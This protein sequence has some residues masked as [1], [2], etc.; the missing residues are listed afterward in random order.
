MSVQAAPE[1]VPVDSSDSVEV[2]TEA[3]TE[4]APVADTSADSGAEA[5]SS[6]EP[7]ALFA[8]GGELASLEKADWFKG[9]GSAEQKTLLAGLQEKHRN[10][11]RGYGGK[12][13]EL[14]TMRKGLGAREA[15]VQAQEARVVRWLAGDGDPIAETQAQLTQMEVQHTAALSALRAEY[16]MAVDGIRTAEGSKLREAIDARSAVEEKLQAFEMAKEA[17]AAQVQEAAVDEMES[18]LDK[19]APDVVGNDNAFE[20]WAVL[21]AQG[22]ERTQALTMVRAVHAPSKAKAA[23]AE[24]SNAMKMM[25]LGKGSGTTGTT[26]AEGAQS[27]DELMEKMRLEVQSTS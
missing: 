26:A 16:E 3:S 2:S 24:P 27:F 23:P 20:A 21:V 5:P 17:Q 15:D 14:S 25:S 19:E 8:W 11:E 22:V 13:G 6:S 12:L 1:V 10:W 7:E 4:A 18:W 9:L